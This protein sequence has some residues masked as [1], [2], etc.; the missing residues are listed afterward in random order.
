MSAVEKFNSLLVQMEPAFENG[1]PAFGD[2]PNIS[3]PE[4]DELF[5]PEPSKPATLETGYLEMLPGLFSNDL[6]NL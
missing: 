1:E 5:L 4:S 2:F 3:R 6:E